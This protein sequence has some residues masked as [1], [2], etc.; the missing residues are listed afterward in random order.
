MHPTAV[1][2]ATAAADEERIRHVSV[3]DPMTLATVGALSLA[4]ARVACLVRPLGLGRRPAR[5]AFDKL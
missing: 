3:I 1:A 4:A 2:R 5:V